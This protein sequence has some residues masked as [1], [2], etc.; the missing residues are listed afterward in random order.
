MRFHFVC[1]GCKRT[2]WLARYYNG[3]V[4]CPHCKTVQVVRSGPSK[5]RIVFTLVLVLVIA[6]LILAR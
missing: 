4:M 1:R 5:K 6:T 2:V 3:I